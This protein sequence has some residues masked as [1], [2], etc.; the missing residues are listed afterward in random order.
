MKRQAYVLC[1]RRF[2][3]HGIPFPP[4]CVYIFMLH[5]TR[6]AA[7]RISDFETPIAELVMTEDVRHDQCRSR[8]W[9]QASEFH[10]ELCRDS[11]CPW[12]EKARAAVTG[13]FVQPGT[14]SSGSRG[15]R[16]V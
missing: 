6:V 11:H 14:G 13:T 16:I 3:G 10:V 5:L 2:L 9:I 1:G 15:F 4:L 7:V 8:G 12:V